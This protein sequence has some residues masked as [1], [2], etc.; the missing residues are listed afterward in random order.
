MP[1]NVP[2]QAPFAVPHGMMLLALWNHG[3]H[4]QWQPQKPTRRW[5]SSGR[6]PRAK[7]WELFCCWVRYKED[8]IKVSKIMNQVNAGPF[9]TKFYATT[10]WRNS[11]KLVGDEV[12]QVRGMTVSHSRQWIPGMCCLRRLVVESNGVSRFKTKLNTFN[13]R[14][15]VRS[16]CEACRQ[17][18][19]LRVPVTVISGAGEAQG[20]RAAEALRLLSS[21]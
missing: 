14:P 17:S 9:L 12:R 15:W 18:S 19:A 8:K 6:A 11:L 20:Q 1:C 5:V 2:C 3:V 4:G 16:G 7:H 10:G 21:P 13:F